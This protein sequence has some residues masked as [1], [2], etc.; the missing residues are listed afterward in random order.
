MKLAPAH[1]HEP[2]YNTRG[3]YFVAQSIGYAKSQL[4]REVENLT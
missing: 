2:E 3:K 1:M 4:K